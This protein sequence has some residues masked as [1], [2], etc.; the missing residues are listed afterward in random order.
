MNKRDIMDLLRAQDP[1]GTGMIPTDTFTSTLQSIKAPLEHDE[2][3]KLLAIYDKKGEGVMNYD[4]LISEQK[5]I[6]AVSPYIV[7]SQAL[8]A[9]DLTSFP[10]SSSP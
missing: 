10:G 6:H 2:L 1:N 5:Y 3:S 8:P 7:Y 4:D 9:K